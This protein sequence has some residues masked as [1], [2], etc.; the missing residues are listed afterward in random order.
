MESPQKQASPQ[1]SSVQEFYWEK[2]SVNEVQK[3][4]SKD[5]KKYINKNENTVPTNNCNVEDIGTT[6]IEGDFSFE[7]ENAREDVEKE[8]FWGWEIEKRGGIEELAGDRIPNIGKHKEE[9][10]NEKYE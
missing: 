4:G 6:K 5:K 1:K 2:D 9:K 7:I 10:G 3:P 8:I